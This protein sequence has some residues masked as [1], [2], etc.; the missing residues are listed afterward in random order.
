MIMRRCVNLASNLWLFFFILVYGGGASSQ[1]IQPEAYEPPQFRDIQD[2]RLAPLQPGTTIRLLTDQDFAPYSFKAASGSPAGL[3]VEIA[4]AACA[5]MQVEC[6]VTGRPFG[7]LLPALAAGEGDAI[8]AGPKLDASSA[9]ATLVTRP[10]FRI[11]G[12]FAVQLANPLQAADAA[13]LADKKIGAVRDTLHARW[14]ETYYAGSEIVPFE[15]WAA[16]GEALRSG[17]IDA[18]FG[19]NLAMIYWLSGEASRKCC[20]PLGGA[21]SDFDFFS[22]NLVVL[23]NRQRPELRAAFDHGLDMAQ[24][25]GATSRILKAY[26]PLSP[27]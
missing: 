10:Y 26:L 9:A 16:A 11:M 7:E 27:W 17:A 8:V 14:L 1:T 21:Y 24:K 20:K 6:T 12:R 13:S 19:D 22:R 18:L 5:E 3:S 2:V 15:N 4:L 25:N 23:V